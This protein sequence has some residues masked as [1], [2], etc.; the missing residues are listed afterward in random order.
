MCVTVML[1]S[2][3]QVLDVVVNKPFQDHI[4]QLYNT[5]GS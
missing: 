5:C 4:K 3:L 2:Q 1:A